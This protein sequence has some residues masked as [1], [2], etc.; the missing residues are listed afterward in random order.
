[1]D[2]KVLNPRQRLR[3]LDGSFPQVSHR[4]KLEVTEVWF[5]PESEGRL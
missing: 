5:W 1:M 3:E 2:R 4:Y